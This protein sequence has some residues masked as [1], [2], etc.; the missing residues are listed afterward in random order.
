MWNDLGSHYDFSLLCAYVMGNFYKERDASDF[1]RICHVHS[2]AIPTEAYS[3]LDS[4][5]AQ[6]HEVARLQQRARALEAEIE[7]RKAVEAE[8]ATVIAHQSSR[9]AAD[10]ERFRLIVESVRDYAIFMLD[11][12]GHVSTWNAGAQ[13]IK[14]YRAEEIIGSHFSRFY[15]EEEVRA[16]KCEYELTMAARDGRFEDEGW[17]VRNDGT[18]FWANVIISRIVAADGKL[19]GF[20]KVTRDL[21]QRRTL[22]LEKIARATAEAELAERRKSEEVRERLLGVVGHDLRAPLSAISMAASVMLKKGTLG[23]GEARMAARIARNADRMAKMISQLL[24]LTRAR[25]GG[26][27][28]IDPKPIDLCEVCTEVVGDL[29][30]ANPER[31]FAFEHA[32]ETR[33]TWDRERMAQVV[34]NLVSNAVQYGRADGTIRVRLAGEGGGGVRLSVHN[35]GDPIP[36]DVLPTI[37][38]PFRRGSE[39]RERS[40]SLGL[41]LF[42]V[43]EIVRSHDGSIEV[44]S[45]AEEGTTF[46]VT[47]P[48]VSVA[49]A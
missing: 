20:A 8:L 7:H 15:V 31:T 40:E 36:A 21:T 37:F 35:P 38:D 47:L 19:L 25:L 46:T 12:T 9:G 22:E 6:L 16:G 28:P 1:E 3:A 49:H 48:R 39:H 11:A 30:V 24:D 41:G 2:R 33:G 23:G 29:E 5:H 42:I 45:N 26:G 4:H 13:R 17:R 43:H 18:R 44:T 34:A 32:G 10:Q 27:I 14:G